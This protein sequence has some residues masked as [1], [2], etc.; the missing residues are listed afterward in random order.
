M[1]SF[2]FWLCYKTVN[3]ISAGG[4]NP[5]PPRG[6]SLA[7]ALNVNRSTSSFLTFKCHYRDIIWRK[8]K[9]I[10]CQGV[11]WPLFCH[12]HFASP[13]IF[14][15]IYI[16]LSSSTFSVFWHLYLVLIG[17]LGGK[18]ILWVIF[19]SRHWNS[20]KNFADVSIFEGI[21]ILI[22]LLAFAA[23]N[24]TFSWKIRLFFD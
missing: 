21:K 16:E 1:T 5:P 22:I 17:V 24:L 7:I 15:C 4:W 13:H 19:L 18:N 23:H 10:A 9:F 2:C 20:T 8:I 12:K 6:F 14:H 11:T 3:A